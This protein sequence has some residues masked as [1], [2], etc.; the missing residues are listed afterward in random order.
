[1][2]KKKEKK[3]DDHNLDDMDEWQRLEKWKFG[4]GNFP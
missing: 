1:M 2:G 4:K 3:S